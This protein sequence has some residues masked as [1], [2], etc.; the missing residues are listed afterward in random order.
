MTTLIS[1]YGGLLTVL[2]SIKW[3]A[4][5]SKLLTTSS[6]GL[7]SRRKCYSKAQPKDVQKMLIHK[8]RGQTR[9]TF[10]CAYQDSNPVSYCKQVKG[11]E[12]PNSPTGLLCLVAFLP[13]GGLYL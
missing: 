5:G 12:Y 3:R 11:K 10:N 7:T 1:G 9:K 6:C 4:A 8:G 2:M 13:N